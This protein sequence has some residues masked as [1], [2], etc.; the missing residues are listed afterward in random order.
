MRA[1]PGAP[2]SVNTSANRAESLPTRGSAIAAR[3]SA[4]PVTSQAPT[5]GASWIRRT[6]VDISVLM[7][8]TPQV[9]PRAD[10][11]GRRRHV[12]G[13]DRVVVARHRDDLPDVCGRRD[14]TGRA[15]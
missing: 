5:P 3:A 13:H 11:R 10:G 15:G 1:Y 9:E 14:R 7:G 2:R 6:G 12:V 8:R 4:Y